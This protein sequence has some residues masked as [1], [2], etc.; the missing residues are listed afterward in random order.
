MDAR[1]APVVTR[2]VAAV[3]G[4]RAFHL[5]GVDPFVEAPFR[6][7]ATIETVPGGEPGR[8]GALPVALLTRP[9]A[10]LLA[11]ATAAELGL[12]PGDTFEIRAGGRVHRLE[13]VSVLIPRDA[14]SVRGIESLL[15]TDIATAQEVTGTT[16]SLTSIDL[17]VP[18]GA[19]GEALP[20]GSA[21]SAGPISFRLGDRPRSA[22]L[23]R[24][25]SVNS[26]RSA[27]DAVRSVLPDLQHHELL[28]PAGRSSRAPPLGLPGRY[29]GP[30]RQRP[31]SSALPPRR[32]DFPPGILLAGVSF[33]CHAHEQRAIFVVAVTSWPS[34]P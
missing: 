10:A 33:A 24:G 19:D 13:L 8:R 16:G 1:A 20:S 9:G 3:A 23:S 6:S 5:L 30:D 28:G 25:F 7:F 27:S 21:G 32:W 15:V 26:P 18:R 31:S 2:D 34:R 11:Q 4:G 17:I 29:L 14:L 12:R 22:D